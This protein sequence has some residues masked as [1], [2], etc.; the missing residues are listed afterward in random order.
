MNTLKCVVPM[1]CIPLTYPAR[2]IWGRI[3][4][5]T[6]SLLLPGSPLF[7]R[8]QL[9]WPF[10]RVASRKTIQM[11]PPKFFLSST[12]LSPSQHCQSTALSQSIAVLIF[13]YPFGLC[14]PQGMSVSLRRIGTVSV[15]F[16]IVS[17]APKHSLEHNRYS[18]NTGWLPF[19]T[20][21]QAL[22]W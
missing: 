5:C 3:S 13:V 20:V 2:F 19:G 15:L 21:S 10:L 11:D 8:S 1:H 4:L 9:T 14:L 22:S 7:S 6:C 18:V 17:L 16:A 12:L